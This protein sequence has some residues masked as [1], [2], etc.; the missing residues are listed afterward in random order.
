MTRSIAL[1]DYGA[2]NLRSAA[3]SLEVAAQN[4][5]LNAHVHVVSD[6]EAVAQ[7][8]Y[9]VLPG[10]GSYE[11]CKSSLASVPGMIE[12][13]EDAV[14]TQGKPFL[15]ICVGMQLLVQDG[16]EHGRFTQG[17]GWLPGS[18]V[19]L[20]PDQ[21]SLKI[22]HMGWN[23]LMLED[24]GRSH[25]VFKDVT[26]RDHVYYVHSYHVSPAS[27]SA[28]LSDADDIIIATSPY[29]GPVTAAVARDNIVGVQFHPEKSQRVGLDLLG[30]FLTWTP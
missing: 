12:A 8:D 1:I 20:T 15:G 6:A 19:R 25:P 3:K 24:N 17:L 22:P 9:I 14:L 28:S 18:C 7:A 10:V 23:E 29:G 4:R 2:G 5:D 27:L 11:H 30:H 26:D 13:L 16:T 21:D